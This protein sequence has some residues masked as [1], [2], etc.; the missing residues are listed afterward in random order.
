MNETETQP[1]LT[2]AE[3]TFLV[4]CLLSENNRVNRNLEDGMAS[5][6]EWEYSID[7]VHSV[8]PKLKALT[9]TK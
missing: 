4:R 8:L 6:V 7:M 9:E 3:Y 5:A 1:K 2:H